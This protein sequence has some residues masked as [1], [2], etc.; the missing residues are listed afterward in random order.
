MIHFL[1]ERLTISTVTGTILSGIIPAVIYYI[2]NRFR[3][4]AD[5]PWKRQTDKQ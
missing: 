4:A 2:S 5:P 1:V 3:K